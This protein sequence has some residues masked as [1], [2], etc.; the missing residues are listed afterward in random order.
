V[1]PEG[2]GDTVSGT[3]KISDDKID[4]TP[5]IDRAVGT[6]SVGIARTSLVEGASTSAVAS[7]LDSSGTRSA[8]CDI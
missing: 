2:P 5:A 8:F 3:V 7:T 4:G 6:A 1:V